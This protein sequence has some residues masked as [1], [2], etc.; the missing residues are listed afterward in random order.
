MLILPC[1]AP[2]RP[3]PGAFEGPPPPLPLPRDAAKLMVRKLLANDYI[4]N[5]KKTKTIQ[6]K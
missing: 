2:P 1:H 4:S 6:W 5:N 3:D